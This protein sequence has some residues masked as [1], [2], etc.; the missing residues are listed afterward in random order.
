MAQ[1]T[2]IYH[3]NIRHILRIIAFC[4]SC[5]TLSMGLYDLY[6]HFPGFGTFFS[7]YMTI[8]IEWLEGQVFMKITRIAL[9]FLYPCKQMMDNLFNLPGTWNVLFYVLYPLY[10]LLWFMRSTLVLIY[11]VLSPIIL[12]FRMPFMAIFN[13]P[14]ALLNYSLIMAGSGLQEFV[15]IFRWFGDMARDLITYFV[16]LKNMVVPATTAVQ[17]TANTVGYI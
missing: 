4:T 15:E 5:V 12:L 2:Q 13:L 7:A 1:Y 17:H 6:K 9:S 14:L 11:E 3:P 16:A 10:Y 8:A